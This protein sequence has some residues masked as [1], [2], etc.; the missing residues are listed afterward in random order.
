M[1]CNLNSVLAL[2]ACASALLV[3]A[4]VAAYYWPTAAPLF[5]AAAMVGIVT[6]VLIPAIKGALFAYAECRGGTSKCS[7]S[8]SINTLGQAASILSVVAF[9]VAAILQLTA[10]AFISSVI[11]AFIGVSMEVAV[12]A[13]V[14]PGIAACGATIIIF[15]GVLTNAYSYKRCMDAMAE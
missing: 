8:Y 15:A 10:L 1:K 7:I 4:I 3:A 14:Y 11:L 12:A 2:I 13:L 6:F 5:V 9:T